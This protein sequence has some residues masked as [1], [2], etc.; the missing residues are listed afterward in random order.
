MCTTGLRPRRVLREPAWRVAGEPRLRRRS[1]APL[2]V[3]RDRLGGILYG[4]QRRWAL[5]GA[6][7]PTVGARRASMARSTLSYAGRLLATPCGAQPGEHRTLLGHRP[8]IALQPAPAA[9]AVC[10]TC[11][12]AAAAVGIR[13][14][15]RQRAA[16]RRGL[17]HRVR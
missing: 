13:I 3:E 7:N 16:Q 1:E 4:L 12:A 15:P 8:E 9:P 6:S 5:A 11:S 17:G 2:A 10:M 14:R